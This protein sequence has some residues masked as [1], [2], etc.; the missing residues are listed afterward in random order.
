M[1]SGTAM[2]LG[3]ALTLGLG[4]LHS[5]FAQST[6]APMNDDWRKNVTVV[7]IAP[8]GT[9]GTATEP[10]IGGAIANAIN[11]CKSKYQGKIG[12]GYRSISV[13]AGWILGFRCG[14]Q[15]IIAAEKTF[16]DAERTALRREYDLRT[17]YVPDMPACVRT[18]TV[19]P[20]GAVVAQELAQ[21]EG[22]VQPR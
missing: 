8:D 7:A 20:T 9:W 4:T 6:S 5:S 11:H 2:I 10:A 17:Q 1:S 13:R 3:C 22:A 21:H 12:C 16:A 19:D 14:V 15:N 18:V